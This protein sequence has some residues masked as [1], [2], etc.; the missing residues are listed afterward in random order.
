MGQG[1]KVKEGL[2]H[3]D[4]GFDNDSEM[5]AINR[6]NDNQRISKFKKGH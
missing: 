2:I 4:E 3:F 6:S 1:L 5:V